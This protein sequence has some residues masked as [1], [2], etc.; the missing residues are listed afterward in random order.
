MLDL[1]HIRDPKRIYGVGLQDTWYGLVS[2]V[3]P[4]DNDTFINILATY[5]Q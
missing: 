1:D 5:V 4:I 2:E 3:V